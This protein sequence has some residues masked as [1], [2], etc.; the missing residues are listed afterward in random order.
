L[1]ERYQSAAPQVQACL[2]GMQ[3]APIIK[4]A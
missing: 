3:P 4:Q 2:P 1:R